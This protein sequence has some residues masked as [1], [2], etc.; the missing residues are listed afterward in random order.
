MITRSKKTKIVKNLQ[1]ENKFDELP[2]D[3]VIEIFRRLSLKTVAKCLTLSKSWA[4]T[5][6]S[7]SFLTS[8][9]SQPCTVIA[10]ARPLHIANRKEVRLHFFL[11]SSSSSTSSFLSRFSTC[12]SLYPDKLAYYYNHAN[13]LISI[14]YG[15]EHLVANPSTGSFISLPRVKTRGRGRVV[16]SFFGYDP[17]SDQ[18]KVLAMTERSYDHQQES[19]SQHQLFTLGEKK[20]WKLLDCSIPDHRPW[21][22]GVCIDG[23]VYYV[24]KTGQGMSQLSIMRFELRTDSLN[25]FTSLPEEIQ[26]PSLHSDT[27][28]NYK[29]KL[30]IAT[31]ITAF[32]FDLDGEK[33]EPLKKITFGIQRVRG[34]TH[35][36]EF[37][38]APWRYYG[39]FYV[40]YYNPDK[41]SIKQKKLQICIYNIRIAYVSLVLIFSPYLWNMSAKSNK[42]TS[43][44][45]LAISSN[46]TTPSSLETWL[47]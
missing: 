46:I 41:N 31:E 12:P 6:R 39:D 16:R 27:L 9:P 8:F 14:G 11:S 43:L 10:F 4:T 21:S 28:M 42:L 23:V 20:P 15:R 35:T 36:G 38:F 37:I 1:E 29:G 22:N 47:F 17:V 7:R 2:P 19:S 26:T 34:T 13:G 33:H 18:Y 44:S 24:A 3:L 30:A 32:I 40:S 5:I 25:L 45:F